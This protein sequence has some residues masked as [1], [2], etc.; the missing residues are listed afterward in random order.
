MTTTTDAA[1]MTDAVACA[2]HPALTACAE[3][4]TTVAA[5]TATTVEVPT[6][7]ARGR[8]GPTAA[9]GRRGRG[10]PAQQRRH[11]ATPR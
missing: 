2:A 5:T 7:L 6:M 3:A 11:L 10:H 1:A 9:D 8:I 4:A